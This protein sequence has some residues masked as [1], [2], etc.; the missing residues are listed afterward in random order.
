MLKGILAGAGIILF[1][2]AGAA[3][4]GPKSVQFKKAS[5]T[6]DL[7]A[8]GDNDLVLATALINKKG[9]A[10]SNTLTFKA[11]TTGII[12]NA[13]WVVDVTTGFRL[14][15]VNIDLIDKNGLV[16]AS[17]TFQGLTGKFAISSISFNGLYL[18]QTYKLRLTGTTQGVGAYELAIDPEFVPT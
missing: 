6:K 11:K 5:E 14:I 12:V 4:A 18:G 3:E 7:G 13:A 8:L 17:D 15:G 1:A 9:S 10:V 2:A 16:V